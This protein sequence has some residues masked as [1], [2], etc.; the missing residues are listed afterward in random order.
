M[1]GGGKVIGKRQMLNMELQSV[2]GGF[3]FILGGSFIIYRWVLNGCI[4]GLLRWLSIRF[5]N[6]AGIVWPQLADRGEIFSYSC[7]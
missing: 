7:L 4:F 5:L 1:G 6:G 2:F 3:S